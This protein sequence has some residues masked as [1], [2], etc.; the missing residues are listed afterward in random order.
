VVLGSS[1]RVRAM[2]LGSA[3]VAAVAVV[4]SATPASAAVGSMRISGWSLPG[5]GLRYGIGF[6]AL[7]TSGSS[8]G[9]YEQ[10]YEYV[11]GTAASDCPQVN[12]TLPNPV[13]FNAG[14]SMSELR[15]E[16]YSFPLSGHCHYTHSAGDGAVVVRIPGTQSNNNIGAI[17]L[18]KPGEGGTGRLFGDVLAHTAVTEGRVSVDIFQVSGFHTTSTGYELDAFSSGPSSGG[19]YTTGPLWDGDYIAFVTDQTTGNQAVGTI[20]VGGDTHLDLDLDVPCFGI[21]D[22]EFHGGVT[23]LAGAY[24]P[25]VPARILDTR[26]GLGI[27][28]S[29][30]AGDGRNSDPNNFKR[31]ISRLNHEFKVTG[32]GGVPTAGVGSVMLNITAASPPSGGIAKFFPKPPNTSWYDDESSFPAVNPR[33]PVIIWNANEDIAN[34]MIVPVGVGGKVRIESVSGSDVN[35]IADVVGWFDE[36][37]PGQT[38]SGLTAVAPQRLL[39]TRHAVGGPQRPFASGESRDLQLAGLAGIP[40]D[41][42]AVVGTVTGVSPA[43]PAYVTVWPKGTG[44]A[45]T[46]VLNSSPGSALPNLVTIGLGSGGWSFFTDQGPHDLLFDAVGYF[47]QGSG[48]L[49]TAMVPS[50]LLDTQAGVGGPR[51]GFTEGENRLLQVA[52]RGGVPADATAVYLSVTANHSTA[53]SYLTVWPGGPRPDTSNLNWVAGTA[54]SDLVLVPLGPG[55]TVQVYNALGQVQVVADVVAYVK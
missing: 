16:V 5:G 54:R 20:T 11:P 25:V 1:R 40:G 42:S 29:V 13:D 8:P 19:S 38:G 23:P 32:V 39:D 51:S 49:V 44:R 31:E 47:R 3:L 55:G 45:E 53:T 15:L 4:G 12:P 26:K 50:L 34:L 7:N 43:R 30:T 24:H 28:A 36:Q 21:D 41:A 14:F 18:P 17:T 37:Q 2:V 27:A 9:G 52:G 35:L 46:S 33:G 22:C 6:D 10:Y 48:G